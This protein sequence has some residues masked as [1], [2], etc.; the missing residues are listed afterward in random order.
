MREVRPPVSSFHSHLDSKRAAVTAARG[1]APPKYDGEH[2]QPVLL[3]ILQRAIRSE[4]C[5]VE[6]SCDECE[7]FEGADLLDGGVCRQTDGGGQ[8]KRAVVGGLRVLCADEELH[9][10]QQ[11]EAR[12]SG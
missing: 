7:A 11:G 8:A 10:V 3:G 2:F 9:R 6:P 5:A 1:T 12:R 4:A